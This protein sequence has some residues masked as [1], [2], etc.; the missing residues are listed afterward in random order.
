MVSR[1][2]ISPENK[3]Y[4]DVPSVKKKEP[5]NSEHFCDMK[6]CLKKA[7]LPKVPKILEY[8]HLYLRLPVQE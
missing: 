2:P 6:I 7:V 3:E 1:G 8:L 5:L 4:I